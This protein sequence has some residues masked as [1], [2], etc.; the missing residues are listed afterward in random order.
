VNVQELARQHTE[1]AVQTLYEC[2][3]DPK[4]KVAAAIAL[5][6]RGWG[7]PTQV[8][9]GDGEK[10]L[11]IR[12]VWDDPELVGPVINGS[13]AHPSRITFVDEESC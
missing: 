2:L 4:L 8:V 10:P 3:R 5:L 7:R 9:A 1:A 12:F 11:A 13:A 6:D